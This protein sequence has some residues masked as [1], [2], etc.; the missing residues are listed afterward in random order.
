MVNSDF[1]LWKYF[2]LFSNIFIAAPHVFPISKGELSTQL[3]YSPAIL[4]NIFNF[5]VY[6]NLDFGSNVFN[7]D[8]KWYAS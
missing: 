5:Y 3:I 8:N 2:L 6:S 4:L 7:P 1:L